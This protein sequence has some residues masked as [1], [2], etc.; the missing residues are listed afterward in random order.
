M[1]SVV[2]QNLRNVSCADL[3]ELQYFEY[4]LDRSVEEMPVARTVLQYPRLVFRLPGA[5]PEY[6]FRFIQMANWA[7]TVNCGVRS[8]MVQVVCG[9]KLVN[10][11]ICSFLIFD[12]FTLDTFLTTQLQV[13]QIR[14][15]IGRHLFYLLDS[16][17]HQS[18]KWGFD[19][20]N[21]FRDK[22]MRNVYLEHT[23]AQLKK[24]YLAILSN[25]SQIIKK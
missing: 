10:L 25:S 14:N 3:S 20:K 12:N 5:D 16:V 13:L 18:E 4:L 19:E 24:L 2:E 8:Q 21:W 9:L 1:V 6:L 11:I 22:L 7:L 23:F 17:A 15:S